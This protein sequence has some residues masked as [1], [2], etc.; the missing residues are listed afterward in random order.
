[1]PLFKPTYTRPI[2]EGAKILDGEDGRR[3][4]RFKSR[5]KWVR[6]EVVEGGQVP[7]RVAVLVDPLQGR[8]EQASARKGV[9]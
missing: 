5:G 9:H 8:A 2:P 7:G 3:I 6:G 4:V 1:M